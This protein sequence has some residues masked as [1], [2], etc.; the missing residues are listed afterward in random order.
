LPIGGSILEKKKVCSNILRDVKLEQV[1]NGTLGSSVP[2]L[3]S[4]FLVNNRRLRINWERQ[5][6]ALMSSVAITSSL[7][8]HP[9][10]LPIDFMR[11]TNVTGTGDCMFLL[12]NRGGERSISP[13]GG[14]IVRIEDP[15]LPALPEKAERP[16]RVISGGRGGREGRGTFALIDIVYLPVK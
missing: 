14:K 16:W 12:W 15:S 9:I 13:V 11:G 10:P 5:T 6:S 2:E 3:Q 1:D 8:L 4:E 7:I